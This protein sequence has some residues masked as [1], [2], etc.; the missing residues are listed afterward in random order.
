MNFSVFVNEFRINH[1]E[2]LLKSDV[3]KTMLLEE[4]AI[5]SGFSNISSFYREFVKKKGISPG[6]YREMNTRSKRG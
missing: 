4:I 1:A 2:S 5:E 3:G 6:K